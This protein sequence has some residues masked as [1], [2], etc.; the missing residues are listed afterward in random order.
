M[1]K[2]SGAVAAIRS[3]MSCQGACRRTS[4]ATCSAGKAGTARSYRDRNSAGAGAPA[5]AGPRFPATQRNSLYALAAGLVMV[6]A[7][8]Y[9]VVRPSLTGLWT[10][11]LPG[12]KAYMVTGLALLA[13][14]F[15]AGSR[16][17]RVQD[18]LETA[19]WATL[20]AGLTTSIM[21]IAATW[22]VAYAADGSR[23]IAADARLH[24]VA[25][26]SAWLAGDNLGGA[27]YSLIWMPALFL[28]LAAGGAII[29]CAVRAT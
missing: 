13:A 7:A 24:G 17:G 26:A 20:L 14:A 18:G 19:A 10:G 25:S 21:I 4:S 11:P 9:C 1:Q 8:A 23:Q 2:P 27:I 5:R 15:L 3:I 6:A 28:A 22:R 29:G 12:M 16:R